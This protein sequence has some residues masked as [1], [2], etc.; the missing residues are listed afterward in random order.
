MP[1]QVFDLAGTDSSNVSAS[2]TVGAGES[3]RVRFEGKSTSAS[4]NLVIIS[5]SVTTYVPIDDDHAWV[6]DALFDGDVVKVNV[7]GGRCKGILET[8]A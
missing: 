7:A 4:A 6:S 8:G 2:V 3:V 5:N 1:S